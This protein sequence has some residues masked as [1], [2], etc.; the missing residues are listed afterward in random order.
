MPVG[1]CSSSCCFGAGW[2]ATGGGAAASGQQSRW[3]SFP[4]CTPAEPSPRLCFPA[5]PPWHRLTPLPTPTATPLTAAH[6]GT[7]AQAA[8]VGS[9]LMFA[10][11]FLSPPGPPGDQVRPTAA[12]APP[13]LPGRRLT[14]P[15]K[16]TLGFKNTALICCRWPY[17]TSS[18]LGASLHTNH[19]TSTPRCALLAF[20]SLRIIPPPSPLPLRPSFPA[21]PSFPRRR[22]CWRSCWLLP[23]GSTARCTGGTRSL[24]ART[25]SCCCAR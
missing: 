10:F 11:R 6:T 7:D 22:P 23:T 8:L 24:P 3:P 20:L 14:E 5:A 15:S 13:P 2:V 12:T 16:G 25:A 18:L 17:T 9:N 19:D 1:S 4:V 21:I